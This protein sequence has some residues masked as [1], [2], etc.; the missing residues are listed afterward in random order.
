MPGG[1]VL[2]CIDEGLHDGRV[3]LGSRAARELRKRGLVI[4]LGAT[5]PIRRHRVVDAAYGDDSCAERDLVSGEAVRLA[6]AVE[7]LVARPRFAGRASAGAAPR[8]RSPIRLC[9]RTKSRSSS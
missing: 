8:I 9:F 6:H 5:R 4:L 1:P 2:E 7:S 3:E